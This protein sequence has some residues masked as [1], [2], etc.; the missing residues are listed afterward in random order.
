MHSNLDVESALAETSQ[1]FPD[2]PNK[3]RVNWLQKCC[4][5]YRILACKSANMIM[6]PA[7]AK[8]CGSDHVHDKGTVSQQPKVENSLRQV[9]TSNG[10]QYLPLEPAQFSLRAS[11]IRV[12]EC[13]SLFVALITLSLFIFSSEVNRKTNLQRDS[14]LVF[15]VVIWASFRFNRVGLPLAVVIVAVI[16]SAGTSSRHP[17]EHSVLQVSVNDA[18]FLL[19]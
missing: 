16:A 4:L 9:H 5:G 7:S 1:P 11:V 17:N 2:A 14:Y 19:L 3:K 10:D 6:A 8:D 12:I 15:P 18:L 13:V